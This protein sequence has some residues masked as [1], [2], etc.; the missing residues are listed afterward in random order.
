MSR[1]KETDPALDQAA[2][3]VATQVDE[4]SRYVIDQINRAIQVMGMEKVCELATLA[5][6]IFLGPEPMM[7]Q[8]GSRQRTLG[9]TF[10]QLLKENLNTSQRHKVFP[11]HGPH[12]PKVAS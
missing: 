10:F 6:E 1:L 5:H 8:D 2:V 3:T 11:W 12:R 7:V 9:G 4:S